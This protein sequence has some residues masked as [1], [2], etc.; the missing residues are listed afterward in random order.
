[1][2]ACVQLQMT[3]H[4][5]TYWLKKQ[6]RPCLFQFVHVAFVRSRRA[7]ATAFVLAIGCRKV[8]PSLAHLPTTQRGLSILMPVAVCRPLC[9]SSIPSGILLKT[10]PLI[11]CGGCSLVSLNTYPFH[12]DPA[13]KGPGNRWN[14]F[15]TSWHPSRL[16]PSALGRSL[17]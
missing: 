6:A 7:H 17:G 12:Q 5:D 1:M 13:E 16:L 8:L 4:T 11:G 14:L 10:S 15:D 3:C 2:L 9:G